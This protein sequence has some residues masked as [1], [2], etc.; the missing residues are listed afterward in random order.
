[1]KNCKYFYII[2]LKKLQFRIKITL[3]KSAIPKGRN[4]TGK[5]E[6]QANLYASIYS[7]GI[8]L[9]YFI[10]EMMTTRGGIDYDTTIRQSLL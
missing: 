1:M 8:Q 6:I 7:G 10:K 9:N 3:N 4:G 2:Y 5:I